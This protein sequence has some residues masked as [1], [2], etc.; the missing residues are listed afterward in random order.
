MKKLF[1]ILSLAAVASLV[2]VS[3]VK[4]EPKIDP[5]T[6]PAEVEN[7]YGVYFPTQEASGNHVYSP[8]QDPVIEITVA[9]TKD[10]GAITVP[11]KATYS[12]DGIFVPEE[13]TFA[14]GQSEAT[15]KVRF[16]AAVEGVNYDAHFVIED[17]QYASL[18]NSNPI[19]L[20]FSILRVEM[21]DWL[22]PVTKEPALITLNEGWWG[23]VHMAKMKYYEVDGLRTCTI[24][25]AEEGNGIWGDAV[26]ATLQFNWYTKNSNDAG[27]NFLEVPKQ[28][29]GFDYDGWASK[30][31]GEATNP[32][33]VYDY[34][35]YW[36]ERGYSWGS[37]GM[38]AN[39]LEE[40]KLTGQID[41]K[42]PVGYY[43]G[44]GGFYFNLRY[45]IPSLS[46][47]FSPSP[48]DFVAISEGF[49]R[50]DYTLKGMETDFTQAGVLPIAVYTGIDVEKV[51]LVAVAGELT[52]TQVANQVAAI[53]DGTAE[54]V[55]EIT[56]LVE[57]E[58]E[59]KDVLAAITGL[60]LPETGVYTVV[61]ATFYTGEDKDKNP[62][63]VNADS[64]S[65]VVN[66]VAAGDEDAK[67]VD[68]TCGIS[69]ASK[70]PGVNTD[71]ALE[72][73]AYG[74]DIVD[75]KIAAVKYIDLAGNLNAALAAVKASKSLPAA[76][77]DAVNGD[78]YVGVA[79]KLLPGTEYYTVIWASNGFE[80]DFF[81]SE[82]SCYTTGD[83]LPIYQTYTYA[84]FDEN[85]APASQDVFVGK[86]F[87]LYATDLFGTLGMNEYVGKVTITDSADE[88]EGPDG[89]G[90]KDEYVTVKGLAGGY[91]AEAGFDDSMTFDLYAGYLYMASN[92]TLNDGV[93]VYNAN[94]AGSCYN[95][96]YNAYFI[97]VL[98]GYY[99]YVCNSKYYESLNFNGLAFYKGGFL[100]A[101]TNY[102]LVDPAKD[103]NGL[104]P[105]S[106]AKLNS[107]V[108]FAIKGAVES[109]KS[110][111]RENVSNKSVKVYG[112]RAVDGI[113]PLKTVEVQL[114]QINF[115]PVSAKK[116]AQSGRFSPL[117][118]D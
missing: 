101:F 9:R 2:A 100:A 95:A 77:I 3:C 28:Y 108:S 60:T 30:P 35:W 87:N 74:S 26:D 107:N 71:S 32:V 45:Y 25:S 114:S 64:G 106:A 70:Y 22:N 91:A 105:A 40:A 46:G 13:I 24:Y 21:L 1:Y 73:W 86:T 90:Y 65:L 102:I 48:Y 37:D 97:P 67:A 94:E 109:H 66:Y 27:Y 44:N 39:W 103:D 62:V 83:P 82:E 57:A 11:V 80:E 5:A 55:V 58:Y 85:F 47:G 8:V 29:F 69:S 18:Y 93:T 34:P 42:Y 54:N 89:D 61:A 113:C 96:A 84:D 36:V 12:E 17:P 117:S 112:T 104:A 75:M 52:P 31:V 99:A 6:N 92:A 49:V 16:D 72:I 19:G 78:G 59:G 4:E 23:E 68:I 76:D 111:V 79:E 51:A 7:C 10:S 15:F 33:F 88:D 50:V 20:D 118:K 41:G 53:A 116:E 43:D 38:G 98:D 56:D 14:D 81:I 115:A 63:L 110:A